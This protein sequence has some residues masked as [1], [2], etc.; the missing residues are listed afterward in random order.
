[1]S[2]ADE[3]GAIIGALGLLAILWTMRDRLR[4]MPKAP[5]PPQPPELLEQPI[6]LDG[7]RGS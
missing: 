5:V 4:P 3:I 6:E 1:M 2:G 7:T